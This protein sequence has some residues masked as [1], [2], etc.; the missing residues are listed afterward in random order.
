MFDGVTAPTIQ[1]TPAGPVPAPEPI[2]R[3]SGGATL[4]MIIGTAGLIWLAQFAVFTRT[5]Q[6][7]DAEAMEA[8][9]ARQDAQSSLLSA[10]GTISTRTAALALAVC[11]V[12]ALI[13]RR[14]A[15][16]A[17]AVLVVGGANVT[18]QLIKAGLDRPDF[19]EGSSNSL[20]SG[21]TTVATSIVLAAL[22]VVPIGLRLL[23]AGLGAF[24]IMFIGTSTVVAGWHRPSDVIAAFAVSLAWGGLAVLLLSL[25][26][27]VRPS[28]GL[29][30]FLIGSM[31]AGA[32]VVG[33]IA[34]GVRPIDGWAGIESAGIVLAAIMLGCVVT[35][36][37]FARL[38]APH[39]R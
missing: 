28:G 34:T 3:Y 33:L 9:F 6:A 12:L 37:W 5:G 30:A 18:T 11:V 16:A 14:F 19:A 21:H 7:M 2:R 38:S 8:M 23:T 15:A 17:A 35:V 10:L 25:R 4:A 36:A 29:G 20:P 13:R 27:T 1:T 39:A 26:R 32:A 31:G 24:A 22:L